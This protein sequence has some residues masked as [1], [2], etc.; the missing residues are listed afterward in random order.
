[1]TTTIIYIYTMPTTEKRKQQ[2]RA[3]NARNRTT[4]NN[5]AREKVTCGC[6]STYARSGKTQH[7]R[8]KK[9]QR[10]LGLLNKIDNP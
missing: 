5:R 9:H 7:T 10:Y 4:R 1:M 3:Y 2:W 6:G 8:S